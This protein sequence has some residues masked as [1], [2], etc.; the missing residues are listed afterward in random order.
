MKILLIQNFD[1]EGLGLHESYL[2]E[3]GI[4]FEVVHTYSEERLPGPAEHDLTIVGGTPVCVR[5]CHLHPFLGRVRTYLEARA[6]QDRPTLGICFGSQL[7][8]HVLGARVHRNPVMEIGG[9]DVRLTEAGRADPL[10]EGFD[11]PFP[12]FH[13]HGDTFDLPTG[14]QLLVEGTDCRN[15]L[16]RHGRL[17]GVQFHVEITVPMARR[18]TVEYAPELEAVG[19]SGAQVVAECRQRAEAMTGLAERFMDNLMGG[20]G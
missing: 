6:M 16:F 11:D 9:Y 3:K 20:I 4:P 18:W 1:V 15:Q 12:V 14:A 5:D 13:W 7:L 2:V 17:I 10:L 19:K 8:A